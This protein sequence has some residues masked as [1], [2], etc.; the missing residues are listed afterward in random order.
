MP[1]ETTDGTDIEEILEKPEEHDVNL[2][3]GWLSSSID[4]EDVCED[5]EDMEPEP[6]F[7]KVSGNLL[8]K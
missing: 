2:F 1:V 5:S 4:C 3:S 8:H 6:H 7:T